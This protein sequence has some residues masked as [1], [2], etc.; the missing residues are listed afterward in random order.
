MRGLR[1]LTLVAFRLLPSWISKWAV[2]WLKRKFVIGVVAV[3]PDADGRFLFLHHTYR[4]KRPWRLPGGLKERHE[5]IFA[6]VVRE[7]F[8]EANLTVRALQVVAVQPSEITLDVAVLCELVE[9]R[10]FVPNDEVDDYVWVHPEE[11]SFPIPEEQLDFI[12]AAR[13]VLAGRA[14][15]HK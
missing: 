9:A 1:K 13:I 2:F 6:T 4:R 5:D 8:E 10:P 11:A 7:L 15:S 14:S 3:L 12:R